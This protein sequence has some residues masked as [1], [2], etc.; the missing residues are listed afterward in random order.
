MAHS[1]LQCTCGQHSFGSADVIGDPDADH[2]S[3]QSVGAKSWDKRR[4]LCSHLF[5][6]ETS[7]EPNE[8][9]GYRALETGVLTYF[10]IVWSLC[11]AIASAAVTCH[12]AS[13]SA[14]YLTAVDVTGRGVP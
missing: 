7:R 14:S 2:S 13:G 5:S 11:A 8:I 9:P 6:Y 10:S 3:Q 1:Q 4:F 12:S